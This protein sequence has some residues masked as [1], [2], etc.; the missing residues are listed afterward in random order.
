MGDRFK[1][2]GNYKVDRW[3]TQGCMALVFA[4]LFFVAWCA[5]FE[6]D[7]LVCKE[8]EEFASIYEEIGPFINFSPQPTDYNPEWAMEIPNEDRE[9]YMECKNPFYRPATWKNKEYLLPGEYG[10][11]PGPLFDW[12]WGVVFFVFLGGFGLNH[13]IHNKPGAD[14]RI[15]NIILRRKK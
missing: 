3:I 5:D 15:L 14:N 1:I 2:I 8:R 7:Y 4:Y 9:H 11:K 10:T 13:I 6:L 12:A